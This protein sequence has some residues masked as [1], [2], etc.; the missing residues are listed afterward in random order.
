MIHRTAGEGGGYDFN[1][2]LLIPPTS[3]KLKH[4]GDYCRKLTFLLAARLELGIFG[5]QVQTT[6]LYRS[7]DYGFGIRTKVVIIQ[8][9]QIFFD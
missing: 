5:S 6:V 2:S 3:K 1:S 7:V 4:L 9:Q 8:D